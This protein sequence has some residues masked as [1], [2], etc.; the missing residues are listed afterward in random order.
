VR[1][2]TGKYRIVWGDTV[3]VTQTGARRLGK[4]AQE[5]MIGGG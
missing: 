1:A 4:A 5:I 3:A 2:E